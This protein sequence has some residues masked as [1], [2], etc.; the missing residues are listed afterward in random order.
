MQPK[1]TDLFEACLYEVGLVNEAVFEVGQAVFLQL[2]GLLS[3]E[4]LRVAHLCQERRQVV[5]LHLLLPE[6]LLQLKS[7]LEQTTNI[8]QGPHVT[9]AES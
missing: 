3:G 5:Q 2:E 6:L 7:L 4:L 1:Q 9:K 8:L